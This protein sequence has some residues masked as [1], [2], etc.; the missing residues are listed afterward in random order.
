MPKR[1]IRQILL[2]QRRALAS[3]EHL[4]LSQSAQQGL[5]DS[6][7]FRRA[8]LVALY[9]PIHNEVDTHFLLTEVFRRD[10]QVCF[11]RVNGESLDFVRIDGPGELSRGAFGIAE[12]TGNKLVDAAEI[13]LAVVPGVGFGRCGYRLGYGGGYYDRAFSSGRPKL[14]AGLAF[15]FQ[16]IKE[17]PAEDH[18]I[19]LDLIV[20]DSEVLAFNPLQ[21]V[22]I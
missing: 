22:V 1:S 18:D 2:S 16:L 6:D 4:R 8:L 12:P 17:L 5:I 11:P 9:A 3:D 21:T 10:K 15:G 19:R 7:P 20:T 14:L 13:D